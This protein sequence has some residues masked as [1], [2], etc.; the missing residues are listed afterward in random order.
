MKDQQC[1][2]CRGRG[3]ANRS[4]GHPH[5]P[6]REWV[7]CKVCGGTG[8]VSSK[9]TQASVAKSRAE[10]AKEAKVKKLEKEKAKLDKEIAEL[11]NPPK[12]KHWWSG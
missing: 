4:T 5:F 10:S 2:A 8:T 11:K 6:D 1:T 12:K 7:K 3:G 9:D